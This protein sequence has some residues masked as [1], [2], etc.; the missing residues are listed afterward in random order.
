MEQTDGHDVPGTFL[1]QSLKQE[2]F[3]YGQNH[4]ISSPLFMRAVEP[5]QPSAFG[6]S[7]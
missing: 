2:P 5:D 7:G 4:G 1:E 6:A 3:L